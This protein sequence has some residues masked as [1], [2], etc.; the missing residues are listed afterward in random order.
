MTSE[1]YNTVRYRVGIV[2]CLFVV[3]SILLM[4]L[5]SCSRSW[6]DSEAPSC[7]LSQGLGRQLGRRWR[8]QRSPEG[9][10]SKFVAM[11]IVIFH[12]FRTEQNRTFRTTHGP[13]MVCHWKERSTMCCWVTRHEDSVFG[14]SD[15]GTLLHGHI[16]FHLQ[17]HDSGVTEDVSLCDNGCGNRTEN[18]ILQNLFCLAWGISIY[19]YISLG[20][21][22]F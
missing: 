17:A 11:Y 21:P 7:F 18:F 10:V 5:R 19:I 1:V 22:V 9:W 20:V 4:L 3:D 16:P 12:T 14:T 6:A 2:A 15:E 8:H 13:E